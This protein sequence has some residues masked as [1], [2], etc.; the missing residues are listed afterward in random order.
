MKQGQAALDCTSSNSSHYGA[1]S[2][3][4]PPSLKLPPPGQMAFVKQVLRDWRA[5][6]PPL[7]YTGLSGLYE[8]RRVETPTFYPAC[9]FV[10]IAKRAL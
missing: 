9:P 7:L 10:N 3:R 4:A 5:I 8:G 2:R 6:I 1:Q